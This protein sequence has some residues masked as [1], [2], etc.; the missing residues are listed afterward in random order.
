MSGQQPNLQEGQQPYLQ[1]GQQ[2][3]YHEIVADRRGPELQNSWGTIVRFQP[4]YIVRRNQKI[5]DHPTEMLV[6]ADKIRVIGGRRRRISR[7]NNRKSK[8]STRRRI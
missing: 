3:M 5:I 4:A 1:E 7:K 8:R 2:V 6:A